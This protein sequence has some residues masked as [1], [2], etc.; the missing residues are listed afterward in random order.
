[1]TK[2]PKQPAWVQAAKEELLLAAILGEP[3]KWSRAVKYG[4]STIRITIE[5]I[6]DAPKAAT[7]NGES[8]DAA[9]P[10]SAATTGSETE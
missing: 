5:T 2:Q 4:S 6:P 3:A 9:S 8:S 10:R 1:M 7:P